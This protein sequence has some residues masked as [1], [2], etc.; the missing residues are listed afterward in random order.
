MDEE[1]CREEAYRNGRPLA[2]AMQCYFPTVELQCP[3]DYEMAKD[4]KA[5]WIPGAANLTARNGRVK[6]ASSGSGKEWR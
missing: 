2:S 1:A 5:S 3:S 4:Y 6:K